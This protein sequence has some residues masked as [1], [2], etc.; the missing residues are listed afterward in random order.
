MFYEYEC[1]KCGPFEVE[2]KITEPSIKLC[3]RCQKEV[4]RLISKT[5]FRLVGKGWARDGY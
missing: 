1:K 2:Q 4:K 5:S 3:P